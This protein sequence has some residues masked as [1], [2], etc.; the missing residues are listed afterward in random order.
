[1]S[2][3]QKRKFIQLDGDFMSIHNGLPKSV[4]NHAFYGPDSLRAITHASSPFAEFGLR[5]LNTSVRSA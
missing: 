2:S 4:K 5:R 1:M 3:T